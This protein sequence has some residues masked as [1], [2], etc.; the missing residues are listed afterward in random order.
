MSVPSARREPYGVLF[1]GGM[2]THL[3]LYAPRFAADPRVRLVGVTDERGI[4]D[5]TRR[6]NE[7]A[8]RWLDIPYLPDLDAALADP[9][10][11]IVCVTPAVERRARVLTTCAAADKHLYLDKPLVA[12]RSELEHVH[13]AFRDSTSTHRAYSFAK[14]PWLRHAIEVGDSGTLGTLTGIHAE[15]LYAK[16]QQDLDTPSVRKETGHPT[17][18]FFDAKRELAEIGFYGISAILLLSPSRVRSVF[19]LTCNYFFEGHVR[20]DIEDFGTLMLR[21]Q[22]GLVASVT[23]GR[24]G[25]SSHA[26]G[27]AQRIRLV[28]TRGSASFDAWERRLEVNG[29]EE[30]V[31][32]TTH[33]E[34]PLSM[35]PSTSTGPPTAPRWVSETTTVDW[36]QQDV[37]EF[38]DAIAQGRKDRLGIDHAVRV[39]EII[40]AAYQS[41]AIRQPVDVSG[42]LDDRAEDTPCT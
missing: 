12:R 2:R 40:L 10:V 34:D 41:A 33:P 27:G 13:A 32:A 18:T 1:V 28:G 14:T 3:E 23:A 8:A 17:Y 25:R 16:G 6:L 30:A 9:A 19:A 22:D 21:M 29:R 39:N 7:E 20:R 42:Y 24:Y 4:D 26:Q 38:I 5:G 35:W 36:E 15:V 31:P 11:S 37:S